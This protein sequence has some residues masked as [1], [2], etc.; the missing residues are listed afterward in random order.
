[1]LSGVQL[2]FI[3]KSTGSI[4]VS[5]VSR[6]PGQLG[7]DTILNKEDLKTKLYMH[8]TTDD[9]A[10]TNISRETNILSKSEVL[11]LS[12]ASGMFLACS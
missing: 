11:R 12:S 4:N 1:M 9:V 2:F 5:L 10:M 3:H 6:Y 8:N 7:S